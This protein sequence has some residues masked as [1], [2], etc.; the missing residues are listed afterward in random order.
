M[1]IKIENGL[2]FDGSGGKPFPGD[3]LIENDKIVAIG[4]RDGSL[5]SSVSDNWNAD[6]II[7]H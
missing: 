2:I 4:R 1:R 3:I 5:P 6:L 7:G